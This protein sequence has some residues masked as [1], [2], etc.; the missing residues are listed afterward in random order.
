MELLL[1]HSFAVWALALS[2]VIAIILIARDPYKLTLIEVV[3]AQDSS[4][5]STNAHPNASAL[6]HSPFLVH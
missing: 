4:H 3:R 5:R 1:P 6:S 2:L